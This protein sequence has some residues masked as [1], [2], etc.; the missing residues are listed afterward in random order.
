MVLARVHALFS[1]VEDFLRRGDLL[2]G[3]QKHRWSKDLPAYE[4][5]TG[6][7]TARVVVRK[8]RERNEWLVAAWA[9]GGE[10]RQVAVTVPGLGRVRVEACARGGVYRA[11]LRNG[12]PVLRRVGEDR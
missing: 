4:F 2:G 10:D 12:K 9:A 3:P 6:D 5:P 7:A 8:H 11:T 1:H